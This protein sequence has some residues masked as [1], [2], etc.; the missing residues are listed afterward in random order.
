MKEELKDYSKDILTTVELVFNGISHVVLNKKEQNVY[1]LVDTAR[2]KTQDGASPSG[3]LQIT[4]VVKF[5]ELMAGFLHVIG[6][7]LRYQPDGNATEKAKTEFDS[8]VKK[9]RSPSNLIGYYQEL[10]SIMSEL[11]RDAFAGIDP[12]LTIRNGSLYMEAFDKRGL[13]HIQMSLGEELWEVVEPLVDGTAHI[14][15]NEDFIARLG[16]VT[17][18]APLQ[19]HI[20]S[21]VGDE[22]CTR[23]WKGTLRK[24]FSVELEWIRSV[25]FLQAAAALN[26]H[27][28]PMV[29]IDFFNVLYYLRMNKAKTH[30]SFSW[31]D[32]NGQEK[33]NIEFHLQPGQAPKVVLHPWKEEIVFHDDVYEGEK[34][35]VV[36]MFNSR[37]DLRILDRFMPYVESSQFTLFDSA[38]HTCVEL[39]G[40]GFACTMTLAGFGK[41]NWYRR[42]QME[43]MLPGFSQ[44]SHPQVFDTSGE[45]TLQ[46]TES[47]RERK[48]L[49]AVVLR[50]DAYFNAG[51]QRFVKR[52]LLGV[53]LDYEKLK[54]LGT[55]DLDAR[56]YLAENRV[57]MKAN[58]ERGALSFFDSTVEEPPKTEGGEPFVAHPRF[59]LAGNGVLRKVGCT[60]T[61]WRTFKERGKG[62]PCGHV[63]ALWLCYC[64]DIENLR[65]AKDAGEDT[66]PR[67]MDSRSFGKGDDVYTIRYNVQ[68]HKKIYTEQHAHAMR[69]Q[70]SST[71]IYKTDEQV[72]AVFERRCARLLRK[73][74]TPVEG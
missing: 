5:R 4:D 25:L 1:I 60:C 63:R 15:I 41:G 18:N 69:P 9:S 73:G 40:K 23:M 72:R 6:K 59:I 66:G 52:S 33:S 11:D 29:R 14:N 39:S 12:L 62:G 74:Y 54:Y 44:S 47:L 51:Q 10:Y 42:L 71:Q 36:H 32:P 30:P 65:E 61:E 21:D 24:K 57:E 45:Y 2:A 53:S 17:P 19:V 64:R 31:F 38:L 22:S 68:G 28:V 13:R 20:G 70:R 46:G 50:G 35:L 7:G 58:F 67:M 55:A 56:R 34:G 27:Q 37:R 3:R 8:L 48:E 26:L 43:T 16:A 49:I